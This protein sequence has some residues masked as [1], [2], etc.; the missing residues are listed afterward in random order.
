MCSTR[1]SERDVLHEYF[2]L[3]ISHMIKAFKVM[4][5]THP[6]LRSFDKIYIDGWEAK[7]KK[8]ATLFLNS[9]TNFEFI[10]GIIILYHL[11]HRI[12]PTPQS[13]KKEQSM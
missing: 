9:F 3:A 6:E 2:Y 7:S 8:E 10:V 11:M 13:F 5:G 4:N 1:W 12:A